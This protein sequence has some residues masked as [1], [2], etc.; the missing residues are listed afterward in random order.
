M[1]R[2]VILFCLLTSFA[3]YASAPSRS[4]RPVVRGAQP[5]TQGAEVQQPR[6]RPVSRPAAPSAPKRTGFLRPILRPAPTP[7]EPVAVTPDPVV[8]PVALPLPFA[9]LRP[10]KR[11]RAVTR[12]AKTRDRAREK[13]LA[14]GRICGDRAIQGEAIGRVP[15]KIAGC[16][17][18][19]AVRVRSV[20]GVTMSTPAVMDCTTARA[21]KSLVDGAMKPAFKRTGGGLQQMR[22]ASHYA[23]RTRNNQPGARISEHGK[24]RAIG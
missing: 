16:G 6:Q 3:A 13:E 10:Q 22:V 21:V 20:S 24:G 5:V 4:E 19:E 2:W 8:E 11:P 1:I 12:R 23:C 7:S 9:V 17:V 14:A 15:G 18:A